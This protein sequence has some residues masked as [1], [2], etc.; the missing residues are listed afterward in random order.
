MSET[1]C[2]CGKPT[3]STATLCAACRTTLEIAI[4][5]ISAYYV[6]LDTLKARLVR[7]GQ[8]GKSNEAPLGMDARFAKLGSGSEV[9]HDARNTVVA[10]VR[11][12]EEYVT[13]AEGPLCGRYCLHLSCANVRRSRRPRDTIPS[14]CAY[15]LRWS[16]WLRT[17]PIG[18]Q[19]LDELCDVE[20]RLRRLIDRPADRWYAGPCNAVVDGEIDIE[21]GETLYAKADFGEVKCRRCEAGYDV[22]ARREWLLEAAED[23]S[24][25]ISVIARAITVLLDDE[26]SEGQLAGRL[27]Q[28]ASRNRIMAT[29]HQVIDGIERPLFRIGTVLDLLA[30]DA[31]HAEEKRQRRT[32]RKAS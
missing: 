31:R 24:A 25:P 1:I 17:C 10:W 13:V 21:C 30:E 16:D 20:S 6:D 19:A 9:E 28:W 14:M 7:F 12:I 5:N 3:G 2:G 8:S 11:Y 26:R 4:V 15:L 27:R 29:R 22:K 23:E 18:D 32:V